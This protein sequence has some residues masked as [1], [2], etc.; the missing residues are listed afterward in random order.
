[1]PRVATEP[2]VVPLPSTPVPLVVE[3]GTSPEPAC[4]FPVRVCMSGL[5]PDLDA[6][7][8]DGLPV[9]GCA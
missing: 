5:V 2:F 4:T 9:L 7:S 1:M 6:I 8:S 3:P